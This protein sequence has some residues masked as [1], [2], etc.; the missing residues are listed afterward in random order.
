MRSRIVSRRGSLS[1]SWTAV[2][3]AMRAWSSRQRGSSASWAKS[4]GNL[5]QK[6]SEAAEGQKHFLRSP[7]TSATESGWSADVRRRISARFVHRR[8]TRWAIA[9]RWKLRGSSSFTRRAT[10]ASEPASDRRQITFSVPVTAA[11]TDAESGP[12]SHR[13][14]TMSSRSTQDPATGS[15]STGRSSMISFALLSSS[16]QSTACLTDGPAFRPRASSRAV[17]AFTS[18]Q[19][20]M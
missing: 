17:Y 6:R 5:D 15:S 4:C 16:L 20:D 3:L 2:Q 9:Q 10:L 7:R 14:F 13:G 19:L 12:P 11:C 8:V 18:R 1:G